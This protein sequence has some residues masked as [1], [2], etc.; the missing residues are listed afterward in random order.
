MPDPG[1][2]RAVYSQSAKLPLIPTVLPM[3]KIL[4]CDRCQHYLHSLY[5]ICAVNPCGPAGE[6]C[7]DFN[8]IAQADAEIARQPLGGGY[9]AGDWIPQPFPAVT[10]NE[11][12]ALLNWH[13]QFTGRCPECETPIAESDEGQWKCDRCEWENAESIAA[14]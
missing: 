1:V 5:L 14:G 9:Y 6:T 13:P 3:P 2:V 12:L 11:Q 10:I 8:A 7:D 4:D